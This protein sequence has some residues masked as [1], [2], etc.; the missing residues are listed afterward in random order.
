MNENASTTEAPMLCT[1][2]VSEKEKQKSCPCKYISLNVSIWTAA[3]L[4][5]YNGVLGS[6]HRRPDSINKIDKYGY[7]A[8]HYAAQKNGIEICS[9][10]LKSGAKCDL[11]SCGATPLHRAA[12]AGS[13][14]CCVLLLDYGAAVNVRDSSFGDN[15]TP[16]QK[17]ALNGH[18]RIMSLLVSRG[19]EPVQPSA[20]DIASTCNRDDLSSINQDNGT[21]SEITHE[22]PGTTGSTNTQLIQQT[23]ATVNSGYSCALCAEVALFL[24]K[25]ADGR[26]ICMACK[27]K[28]R[29]YFRFSS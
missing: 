16:Y 25:T 20:G 24:S 11:N 15:L 13:Y 27:N 28:G 18:E 7:T 9:L 14:E 5:D 26:L 8:L 1:F 6:V 4:N 29:T 3:N 21:Q 23:I 19:A 10:L 12:A 2:I 22:T 17:A